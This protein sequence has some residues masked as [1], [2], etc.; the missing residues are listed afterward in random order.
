MEQLTLFRLKFQQNNTAE[1]CHKDCISIPAPTCHFIQKEIGDML[2]I[3]NHT[4]CL[5]SLAPNHPVIDA[6][7]I[8]YQ[9][10]EITVYYI[11]ISFLKYARH[12][13]K[14]GDLYT[15]KITENK[16][17]TRDVYFKKSR[18]VLKPD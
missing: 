1:N 16:R 6:C 12:S 15:A 9:S 2:D 5:I 13:K 10:S 4:V 7:I 14:R 11:Q 8:D 18:N 3:N 17:P